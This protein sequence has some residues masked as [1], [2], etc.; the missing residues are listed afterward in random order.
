MSQLLRVIQWATVTVTLMAIQIIRISDH[1]DVAHLAQRLIAPPYPA[2]LFRRRSPS[3]WI[4]R[5]EQRDAGRA[6]CRGDVSRAG[7]NT[8]I[9]A[10]FLNQRT[11]LAK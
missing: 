1:D 7:V 11:G 8:D 3:D 4:G 5:T 10:G 2:P 6:G 9:T